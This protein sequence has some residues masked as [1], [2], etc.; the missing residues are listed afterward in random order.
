MDTIAKAKNK[1]PLDFITEL[2]NTFNPR[3]VDKILSGMLEKRFATLRVNNLKYNI[4]DLKKIFDNIGIEY[5]LVPWYKDALILLNCNESQIQNLEIYKNGYIYLQSL[6]SMIPPLVLDP[7]ENDKVLDLTA[8][9]GSK[10]TQMASMMNNKGY[11]LANELDKIRCDKLKYN[12]NMQGV[13][14]CKVING[15]GEDIGEKYKEQFD[16]VLLD[17]PCSGEGRFL[18]SDEK[19]YAN[20]NANEVKKLV[21]VQKDLFLS[22]DKALKKGGTMVYSTCTLNKYENEEILNFALNN[23]D[24]EIQKINIDLKNTLKGITKGYR[25]D[26]KNAIRVLPTKEQEGFFVAKILKIRRNNYEMS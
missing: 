6:S 13:T 18:L 20:W 19:T 15:R 5:E 4:E 7:K 26:I 10:T 11:I 12:I 3:I 17:T 22:A 2:N 21:K 1:L 16:K 8:A 9:P 23:L 14:I 24:I 25:E